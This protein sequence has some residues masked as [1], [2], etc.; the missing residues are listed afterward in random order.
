MATNWWGDLQASMNAP[1]RLREDARINARI[2]SGYTKHKRPTSNGSGEVFYR[3]NKVGVDGHPDTNEYARTVQ[4]VTTKGFM[5]QNDSVRRQA[6]YSAG[7]RAAGTS[8]NGDRQPERAKR[9]KFSGDP[10]DAPS[11]NAK[12]SSRNKNNRSTILTGSKGALGKSS[13]TSKTLL[14]G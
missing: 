6:V 11:S 13:T 9:A 1:R 3:A 2:D 12:S 7:K 8:R 4:D 5:G 14:G 10:G